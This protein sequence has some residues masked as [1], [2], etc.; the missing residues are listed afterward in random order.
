L[1]TLLLE[2]LEDDAALWTVSL[3]NLP[4]D[5]LTRLVGSDIAIKTT[6]GGRFLI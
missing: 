5:P 3:K 4:L 1:G 2:R 6:D